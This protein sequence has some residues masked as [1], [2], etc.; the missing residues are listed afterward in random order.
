MVCDVETTV[1]TGTVV[2]STDLTLFMFGSASDT[3]RDI[4]SC[5]SL[6][7][8]L[9]SASEDIKAMMIR[10]LHCSVWSREGPWINGCFTAN[11][12]RSVPTSGQL[13]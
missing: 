3:E 9:R 8:A 4:L 12:S 13:N 1:E 5:A 10:V 6:T 7:R 11:T 2:C